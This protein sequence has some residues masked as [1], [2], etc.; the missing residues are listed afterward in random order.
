MY[1]PLLVKQA[2]ISA[3]A[4]ASL[5][6]M[7][8]WSLPMEQ[9]FQPYIDAQFRLDDGDTSE[10]ARYMSQKLRQD[11]RNLRAS[12]DNYAAGAAE[13]DRR[14]I[15]STIRLMGGQ[16]V[17]NKGRYGTQQQ[18]QQP[19]P[20]QQPAQ[21]PQQQSNDPE[22][23]GMYGKDA[24]RDYQMH[25]KYMNDPEYKAYTEWYNQNKGRYGTPQ[26]PQQQP[27][28]Q[29]QQQPAQQPQQPAGGIQPG[30]GWQTGPFGPG[31][32]FGGWLPPRNRPNPDFNPAS[33][34]IWPHKGNMPYITQEGELTDSPYGGQFKLK[35]GVM[36]GVFGGSGPGMSWEDT[37]RALMM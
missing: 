35:S 8:K 7:K 4:A 14:M 30:Q 20:Q 1:N 21:Q 27:A 5:D 9:R 37:R 16:G 36:G 24:W 3:D 23:S 25:K 19:T 26:Q 15:D 6:E 33:T 29:P 10:R 34:G 12:A 2:D 32:S 13:R 11:A 17:E 22:W 18:P 28:Q 31:G